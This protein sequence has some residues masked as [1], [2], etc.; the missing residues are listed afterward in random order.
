MGILE[1]LGMFFKGTGDQPH[2]RVKHEKA[3]QEDKSMVGKTS[4][5]LSD[6]F[7]AKFHL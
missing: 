6:T 4:T 1:D 7:F 2:Y 3:K 5:P